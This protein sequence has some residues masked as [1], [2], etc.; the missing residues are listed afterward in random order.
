MT[1]HAKAKIGDLEARGWIAQDIAEVLSLSIGE[2]EAEMVGSCE[3]GY[4]PHEEC[5]F[6][7]SD[8]EEADNA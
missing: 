1:S 4:L 5:R 8:A 6:C 2:V 3:H 7:I